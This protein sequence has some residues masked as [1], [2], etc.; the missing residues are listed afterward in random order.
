MRVS[1]LLYRFWKFCKR[2]RLLH[3]IRERIGLIMEDV[4]QVGV[5]TSTHGVRGEVKVFPTTDDA[6]RFKRLKEVILD[7]GKEQLTLEIEGVKFF[8]QFVILK[9]KGIDN[10]NDVERYRQ[11]SLYVTRNNA[12]RLSKDEYFIADLIN[13]RVENEEGE[14][15]GTLRSVMETGANDVYVIEMNDGRELLLPAIKQC[16]LKVDVEAG[17]VQ[18]HILDGLID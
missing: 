12:V 14:H 15:I 13:L 17:Y 5:I 4:F 7:T 3:Y 16:V 11:K 9:F 18:I 1:P 8:K 2:G 10:I 6:R